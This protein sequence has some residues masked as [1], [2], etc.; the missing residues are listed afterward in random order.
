[1]MLYKYVKDPEQILKEGYIRAT[2]LSALNDPFEANYSKK[3]LKML[4]KEIDEINSPKNIIQYIEEKKHQ[5][6][7]ISFSET[8]D[9]LLMWSHY[10]NEHKGALIGFYFYY[11]LFHNLFEKISNTSLFND[12]CYYDGKCRQVI[13]RKQPMYLI[14]KF[15][16][17]YNNISAEGEDRLLFEIFLQK[18]DEWIYEKEQRIILKL[19]QADRIILDDINKYNDE[20]FIQNMF[21][22]NHLPQKIIKREDKKIHIFLENIECDLQRRVWGDL[23]STL[24]KDNP[25]IIYLFKLDNN[26]IYSVSYG[27]NAKDKI[28]NQK[29]S[30]INKNIFGKYKVSLNKKNYTLKF[31][32]YSDYK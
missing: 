28:Q 32:K 26:C 18:S 31:K 15:D 6:G 5:I 21:D 30:Y 10:A 3:A 4:V 9:N 17:D 22:E 23:L 1:M 11:N 13:Y 7:I 27:F 20:K 24:A 19:S 2:Q 29:Y 8:K 16:R 25:E 12:K 14:D